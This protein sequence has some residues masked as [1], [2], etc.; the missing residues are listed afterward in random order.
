ML[1][2]ILQT[3][4]EDVLQLRAGFAQEVTRLTIELQ[5]TSSKLEVY[6][7]IEKSLDDYI[8]QVGSLSG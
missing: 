4:K 1:S 7:K 6:N 3:L 8:D 5:N 2:C